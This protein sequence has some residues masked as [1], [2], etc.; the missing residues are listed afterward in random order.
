M[1]TEKLL[2]KLLDIASAS[3]K[4]EKISD[5]LCSWPQQ[6]SFSL[7]RLMMFVVN[8][9]ARDLITYTLI[10]IAISTSP[11]TLSIVLDT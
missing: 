4:V 8:V 5:I 9:E 10:T 3:E 11:T 2:E 7:A 6:R 1:M